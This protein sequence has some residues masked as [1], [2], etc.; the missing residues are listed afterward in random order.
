[1]KDDNNNQRIVGRVF[2][3]FCRST[4]RLYKA[5][6]IK[7]NQ[8]WRTFFPRGTFY[9]PKSGCPI[10]NHSAFTEGFYA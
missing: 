9:R 3:W 2:E 4:N 7:Q 1:M 5:V 10:T 6:I 8:T